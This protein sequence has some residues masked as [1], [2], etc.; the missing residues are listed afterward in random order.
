M[1]AP[2]S[3]FLSLRAWLGVGAGSF[4][5]PP[6]AKWKTTWSVS[7][8]TRVSCLALIW[9]TFSPVSIVRNISASFFLRRRRRAAPREVLVKGGATGWTRGPGPA[10][11]ELRHL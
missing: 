9:T 4:Q 11:E 8:S 3:F 5:V 7:Y 10:D 1:A 2:P 6:P